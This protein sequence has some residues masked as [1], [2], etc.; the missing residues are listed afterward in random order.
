MLQCDTTIFTP[1]LIWDYD[2]NRGK[3][4]KQYVINGYIQILKRY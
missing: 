4:L 2:P 3:Q 1:N